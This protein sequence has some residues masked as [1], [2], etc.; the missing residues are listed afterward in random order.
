[1][2][3]KTLLHTG[4]ID[5]IA[6]WM[7]NRAIALTQLGCCVSASLAFSFLERSYRSIKHGTLWRPLHHT[8]GHGRQECSSLMQHLYSLFAD[9]KWGRVDDDDYFLP[10]PMSISNGWKTKKEFLSFVFTA[11]LHVC[12]RFHLQTFIATSCHKINMILDLEF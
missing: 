4:T 2:R 8:L 5:W 3:G 7:S 6:L 9:W 12:F 10:N 1:M 11:I